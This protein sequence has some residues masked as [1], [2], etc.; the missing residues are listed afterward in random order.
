MENIIIDED[1]Y[2]KLIDFGLARVIQD[3]DF[4]TTHCGKSEYLAPEIVKDEGH[5]FSVDW[6]SLGVMMY[7]L[8]IGLTPFYSQ[9]EYKMMKK[10]TNCKVVWPDRKKYKNINYS[11]DFKNLVD[12]L[13]EKD[14]KKRLGSDQG[15]VDV[16]S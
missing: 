12:K 7:E 14:P 5:T 4:A 3:D 2:I 15:F 11:D 10:I 6:W 13:L 1:Y 8:A 9:K 16:I